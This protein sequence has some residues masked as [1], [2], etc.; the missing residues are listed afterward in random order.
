MENI[1]LEKAIKQEKITEQDICDELYEIC[2]KVHAEC[3]DRCPVFELSLGLTPG[4]PYCVCH[5]SGKRMLRFIQTMFG[6]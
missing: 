1:I 5:K 2:D 4:H 6:I 3:N